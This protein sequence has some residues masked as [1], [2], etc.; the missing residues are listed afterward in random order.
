MRDSVPGAQQPD[1]FE[2]FNVDETTQTLKLDH[3]AGKGTIAVAAKL[4]NMILDSEHYKIEHVRRASCD[5]GQIARLI[6]KKRFE[7]K[8][9]QDA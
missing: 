8:R 1:L 6:I 9:L 7:A 5:K 2:L 4:A 3:R